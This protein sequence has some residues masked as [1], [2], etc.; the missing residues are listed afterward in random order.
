MRILLPFDAACQYSGRRI[1]RIS[2]DTMPLKYGRK[3]INPAADH[4]DD[5]ARV[6]CAVRLA[7]MAPVR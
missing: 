7:G 1:S 6:L 5:S 3:M 2:V 4:Q